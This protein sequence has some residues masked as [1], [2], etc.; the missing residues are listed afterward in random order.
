MENCNKVVLSL[1]GGLDSTCLLL[2]WLSKGYEV[3][4]F[5]FKYGQKHEVELKKVKKNIKLLQSMG[6]PV[7]YQILNLEDIFSDSVSTLHKTGDAI[8]H[9]H[10]DEA[11]M[12]STVV[13][14][15]NVIFSAI[16]FAKALNWAKREKCNVLISMGIHSGDHFIYKDCRPES[17]QMARE[18]Y[19]ISNDD[20][21]LVDYEAPF[22][23]IDKSEVLKKGID[24]MK[25][26]GFNMRKIKQVLRNTHTCYDPDQDGR[27]CGKCGSCTERLEAFEKNHM[28][29]P[30][31][32]Q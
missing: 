28:K 20:S 8:P 32:Y 1:S 17:Q 15:R 9:G 6:L 31:R 7:E 29:D 11:T 27:S 19:K 24:A 16:I 10:Y 22:V 4:A 2:Y 21:E 30:I 25:D 5:S 23:N 3:R 12:A 14:Q 13:V 26:L 18:L